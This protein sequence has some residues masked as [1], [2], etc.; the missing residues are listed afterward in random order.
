MTGWQYIVFFRSSAGQHRNGVTYPPGLTKET[1]LSGGRVASGNVRTGDVVSPV[2]ATVKKTKPQGLTPSP[3]P[4]GPCQTRVSSTGKV[5]VNNCACYRGSNCMS[6]FYR[7]SYRCSTCCNFVK[8]CK[9]GNDHSSR[10]GYGGNGKDHN[11]TPCNRGARHEICGAGKK[12][13][14]TCG[15]S[16]KCV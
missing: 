1:V 13:L 5:E 7:N 2:C 10:C 9:I 8:G 3:G 16:C 15:T 11:P 4:P 14:G 6:S 12:A